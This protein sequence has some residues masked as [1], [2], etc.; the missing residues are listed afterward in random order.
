M[1]AN[2]TDRSFALASI[3]N[4]TKLFQLTHTNVKFTFEIISTN[5]NK[6]KYKICYTEVGKSIKK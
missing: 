3:Y 5:D 6:H 1:K 2:S 4:S